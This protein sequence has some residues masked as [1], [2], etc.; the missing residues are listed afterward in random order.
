MLGSNNLSVG[1]NNLNTTFSGVIQDDGTGGQLTKFGT[2]TLTLSGKNTYLGP[3]NI[4][5]GSL[6][7]TSRLGSGNSHGVKVNI[8]TFGGTGTVGGSVTVGKRSGSGAV[9]SPGINGPGTLTIKRTLTF[10]PDGSY[11]F[12]LNSDTARA[13]KV[14]AGGVAIPM[15]GRFSF[16]DLGRGILTVGTTFIV[17]ENK[18]STPISGTFRNLEDGSTFTVGSNTF[19]ANYEG[20]D[21]NDLTLTVQ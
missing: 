10:N 8:G 20:G 5:A 16:I 3:T 2:G 14:V 6:L 13:D 1:I 19:Q 17:I 18:A 4:N 15:G 11:K 21:G 7:L 9:L 12:E